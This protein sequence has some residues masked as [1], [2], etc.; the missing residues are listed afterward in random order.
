VK[1]AIVTTLAALGLV[2]GCGGSDDSDGGSDPATTD[3]G[4]EALSQEEFVDQANALC[5]ED[6][7]EA[8]RIVAEVLA[9]AQAEGSTPEEATAE[10]LERS[11][12][13]AAQSVEDLGEL[14]PP[15]EIQADFDEYLGRN[16]QANALIPE[17]A[18]ATR[19]NDRETL[20]Q[21]TT[22]FLEIARPTRAF[23]QEQ[24]I[25]DCLGDTPAP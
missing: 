21:L 1:R 6:K 4:S 13:G 2:A 8:E 7:A 19:E 20:T 3:A 15:E 16:E 12:E 17:L 23:A 25:T 18:R 9:E 22:E 14:T 11:V 24:G 5:R 10:G